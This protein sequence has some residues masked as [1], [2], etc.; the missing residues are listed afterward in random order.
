MI[1]IGLLQTGSDVSHVVVALTEF[2]A[3]V[4]NWCQVFNSIILEYAL[5]H[6][7]TGIVSSLFSLHLKMKILLHF[8]LC[9]YTHLGQHH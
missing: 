2:L 3:A 7:H 5:K 9:C 8:G 6:L 4:F 1:E